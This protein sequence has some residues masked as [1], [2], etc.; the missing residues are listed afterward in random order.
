M[1]D[2]PEEE[3]YSDIDGYVRNM[4]EEEKKINININIK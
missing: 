1:S 4:N 2:T 3:W